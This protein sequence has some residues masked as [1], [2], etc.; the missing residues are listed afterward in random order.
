MKVGEPEVCS[1]WSH[2][3]GHDWSYL[4]EHQ[5]RFADRCDWSKLDG[6]DWVEL[7]SD[8]AEFANKCD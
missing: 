5:P 1:N 3:C 8:R 6:C 7:L 4:L 2:L